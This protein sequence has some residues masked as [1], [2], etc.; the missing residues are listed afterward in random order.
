[1]PCELR[2]GATAARSPRCA[3]TISPPFRSGRL[4]R[5]IPRSTGRRS[6]RSC[7]AVPIRRA[8]T[9]ATSRAWRYCSRA[10]QIASPESPS[11]GDAAHAIRCGETEFAI[12]GGVESMTRAPLVMGKAQEAFQR[13]GEIHD[14]TL[15]W[16]FVNPVLEAQYGIDSMAETGENV[17]EDYQVSRADQ[18]SFALR[19]QQRAGKA[20]AA[21]YF[22]EEIVPVEMRGKD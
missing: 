5:A 12:A 16:R 13:G 17:A 6:T 2:S 1:M 14:T 11:I 8:K 10:C 19:S 18:D 4:L 21:G 15:G 9:I 22:A 3:P 7:S 20:M